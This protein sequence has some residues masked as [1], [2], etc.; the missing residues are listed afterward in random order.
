MKVSTASLRRAGTIVSS[1][2]FLA[3]SILF[4]PPFAAHS[5]LGVWGFI[6]GSALMLVTSLLP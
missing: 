4:L 3:G 6:A 5:V 1:L 2:C